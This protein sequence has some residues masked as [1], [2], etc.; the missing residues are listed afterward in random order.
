MPQS[1]EKIPLILW[2]PKNQNHVDIY[3]AWRMSLV[4][5]R[6][7]EP[8]PYN[9]IH[10]NIIFSYAQR[11][12]TWP[13]TGLCTKSVVAFLLSI[14]SH[15]FCKAHPSHRPLCEN[16]NITKYKS[17]SSS[18]YSRLH[19]PV[20]SPLLGPNTFLSTLF[21]NTISPCSAVNVKR[22]VSHPYKTTDKIKVLNIL[23]SKREDNSLDRAVT[24]FPEFK[25][26]LISFVHAIPICKCRSQTSELVHFFKVLMLHSVDMTWK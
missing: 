10:F 24:G 17:R 14:L 25:L 9:R 3:P 23:I 13:L 2:D 18:L 4:T 26:L 16:P 19:S 5:T 8:T 22:Q 11:I 20:T 12:A 1:V 6:L 21:S 7:I 15:A